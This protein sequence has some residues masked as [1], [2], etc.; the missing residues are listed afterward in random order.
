MFLRE[1]DKFWEKYLILFVEGIGG[2][3]IAMWPL[4]QPVDGWE[5]ALHHWLSVASSSGSRSEP[6]A[7][8][9]RSEA[10]G[11]GRWGK[12]AAVPVGSPTQGSRSRL[13]DRHIE[14][15]CC[16]SIGCCG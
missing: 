1:I 10:V 12:L 8:C 5:W 13:G 11:H 7:D 3:M 4:G 16:D 14:I 9:C 6:R 2:S 15:G